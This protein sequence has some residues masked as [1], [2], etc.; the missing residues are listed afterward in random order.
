[1]APPLVHRTTSLSACR[2]LRPDALEMPTAPRLPQQDRLY[3][4]L[5]LALGLHG[6]DAAGERCQACAQ[7]WP[8]DQV[9]SAFRV[10]EGF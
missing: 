3:T 8:C 4:L 5:A 7:P 1:M 10:R 6:P 2:Q 9:R